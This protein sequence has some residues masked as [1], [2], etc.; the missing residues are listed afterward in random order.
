MRIDTYPEPDMADDRIDLYVG[1]TK[2]GMVAHHIYRDPR[3]NILSRCGVTVDHT[4]SRGLAV[5]DL[6]IGQCHR[7]FG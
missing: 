1:F 7:C 6:G 2:T 3:G 4:L 5:V